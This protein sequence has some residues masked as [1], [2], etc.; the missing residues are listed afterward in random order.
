MS[1]DRAPDADPGSPPWARPDVV[2]GAAFLA[3]AMG[4]W[5]AGRGLPFGSARQPGP[6]FFPLGLTLLL[7]ALAV[8][9]LARGLRRAGPDLRAAWAD[10]AGR[11]RLLL[12][13]GALLGYVATV[14]TAGYL[15]TTTGLFVVLVRWVGGRGWVTTLVVSVLAAAASH[16][17][18]ARTLGVSLPAGIWLP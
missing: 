10:R 12:M 11:H 16:A 5:V 1:P 2:A 4:A 14:E 9:L 13:S 18:F 7:A 6:G 8:A 3:L 17:L 15:V